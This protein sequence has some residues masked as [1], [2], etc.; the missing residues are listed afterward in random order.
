MPFYGWGTSPS[1][2]LYGFAFSLA[3]LLSSIVSPTM[4]LQRADED[5][6]RMPVVSFKET[7]CSA[8]PMRF[9]EH[10]EFVPS[11]SLDIILW[12]CNGRIVVCLARCTHRF[13]RLACQSFR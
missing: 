1:A 3:L 8:W 5:F 6:R 11:R 9:K 12:S 7:T 2:N 10:I 4:S 13:C